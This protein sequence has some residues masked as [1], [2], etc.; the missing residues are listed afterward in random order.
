MEDKSAYETGTSPWLRKF[1]A[2]RLYTS[3]AGKRKRCASASMEEKREQGTG[4]ITN[5]AF[6]HESWWLTAGELR[7]ARS[8]SCEKL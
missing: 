5:G 8:Y 3:T 4:L 1:I 6:E 7:P 2:G